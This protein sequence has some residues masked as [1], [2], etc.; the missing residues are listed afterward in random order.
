M[1]VL[2]ELPGLGEASST[3]LRA[4]VIRMAEGGTGDE[5]L[6]ELHGYPSGEGL[7]L[8]VAAG[9]SSLQDGP[10]LLARIFELSRAIGHL[11]G[12]SPARAEGPSNL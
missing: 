4:E 9:K 2:G 3:K 8:L 6:M 7:D 11:V 12:A 5:A 10:E 1:C